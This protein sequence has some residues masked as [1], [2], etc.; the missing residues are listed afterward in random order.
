MQQRMLT[1]LPLLTQQQLLG[2][3]SMASTCRHA[4]CPASGQQLSRP[5]Q[6]T[7]VQQAFPTLQLLLLTVLK[8]SSLE[9]WRV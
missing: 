3:H 6:S 7:P 4:S 9:V 2:R 5:M 8:V 1:V